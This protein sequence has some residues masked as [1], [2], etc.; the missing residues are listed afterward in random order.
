MS[1]LT[2]RR[3]LKYRIT[4]II[5]ELLLFRFT[6]QIWTW[7]YINKIKQTIQDRKAYLKSLFVKYP[8]GRKFDCWYY[9]R[10]NK[11]SGFDIFLNFK[12]SHNE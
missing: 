2:P 4:S 10:G 8:V 9:E 12:R 3:S 11:V 5:I 1:G 7:Y 6:I